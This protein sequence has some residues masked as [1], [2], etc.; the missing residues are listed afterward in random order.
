MIVISPV[1]CVPAS[2]LDLENRI[3]TVGVC[4]VRSEDPEVLALCIKLEDISYELAELGHVLT[5]LCT[6]SFYLD[7]IFTEVRHTEV[8]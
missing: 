1:L 2:V 7:C 3:Q 5:V 4:L 8:S 6:V